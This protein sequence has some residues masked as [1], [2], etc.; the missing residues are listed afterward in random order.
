MTVSRNISTV[1]SVVDSDKPLVIFLM[2]PTASGKTDLAIALA[3]ILPID[4]IS[5][6]SA[7][8]YWGMDIGTAKPSADELA[9][10]P[11]ALIDIRD[12]SQSYSAAEFCEDALREIEASIASD[13][14][15]LLVGGT[16]MYFNALLEGLA[17]MPATRDDIRRTLED[18]AK[19]KGWPQLHEELSQV[20]PECARHIHPNH[21]QRI[22]RA[23][24]VFRMTGK[25]MTF[26]KEQQALFKQ[27]AASGLTDQ[28]T[29]V[30]MALMPIDRAWLH[31][32]IAKRYKLMLAQGLVAEVQGLYQ[33]GDLNLDMPSMRS[34]GYRQVWEYLLGDYDHHTMLEKGLAA[35]RQLAKRQITWLRSWN[36]LNLIEISPENKTLAV[37]TQKNIHQA[38]NFLPIQSI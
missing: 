27:S 10:A 12:P 8:I 31:Q 14:I 21:S 26:Y 19:I 23:L 15:P 38:L 11:H 2:G 28:Y 35:T 34:V 22:A 9:K 33:R 20:D 7:L 13:R 17:E 18:E 3:Q 29:V 5:V 36:N 37:N 1:Q 30:Q 32:R 6:D 16:M 24:A 25:T 4:V